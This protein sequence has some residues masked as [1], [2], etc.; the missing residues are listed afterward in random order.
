[1]LLRIYSLTHSAD[2]TKM[3]DSASAVE[4][5]VHQLRKHGRSD[6]GTEDMQRDLPPKKKSS[7]GDTLK[8]ALQTLN[9]LKLGL[10]Y[11]YICQPG[12]VHQPTSPYKLRSM[13]RC[14]RE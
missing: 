2:G 3:V 4:A 5:V 9:G 10:Q 7:G 12:P 1:M 14:L 8:N 11:N 13:M 6:N